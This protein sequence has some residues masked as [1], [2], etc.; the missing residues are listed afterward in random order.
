M[1]KRR[2][3]V[4]RFLLPDD[5]AMHHDLRIIRMRYSG[6]KLRIVIES[7]EL[8]GPIA[9]DFGGVLEFH[10]ANG[11]GENS[12]V[13]LYE[14]ESHLTDYW[15]SEDLVE[16]RR[17]ETRPPPPRCFVAEPLGSGFLD[18]QG[19]CM[20]TSDDYTIPGI[21]MLFVCRTVVSAMDWSDS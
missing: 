3:K 15:L 18:E 14:V 6:K 9:F 7:I 1:E 21:G 4:V 20:T 17:D 16:Y 13:T 8:G 2:L 5:A 11:I 12:S 10:A 19:R